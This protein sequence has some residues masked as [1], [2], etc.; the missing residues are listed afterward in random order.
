[1]SITGPISAPR[2]QETPPS[3]EPGD[4]PCNASQRQERSA[5]CEIPSKGAQETVTSFLVALPVDGI[6]SETLAHTCPSCFR[7]LGKPEANP[8]VCQSGDGPNHDVAGGVTGPESNCTDRGC[9]PQPDEEQPPRPRLT[10]G[11]R[12]LAH[13]LSIGRRVTFPNT[14][15]AALLYPSELKLFQR[16]RSRTSILRLDTRCSKSS[17][18]AWTRRS[19]CRCQYSRLTIS[20]IST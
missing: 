1:M 19:A 6:L 4:Y 2:P 18:K 12:R 7:Q 9:D 17:A 13:A 20:A 14:A 3:C 15:R 8:E 16:M 5:A 11:H 10:P